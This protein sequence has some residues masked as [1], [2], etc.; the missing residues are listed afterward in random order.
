M[1]GGQL[2]GIGGAVQGEGCAE[3]LSLGLQL[4]TGGLS[5]GLQAAALRLRR[6]LQSGALRLGLALQRGPFGA[7]IVGD[8]LFFAVGLSLEGIECG[9]GGLFGCIEGIDQ[10]LDGY[11][12]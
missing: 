12:C 9:A 5:G 7:S 4:L 8:F 10:T 2:S 6:A 3:G 11:I 1:R